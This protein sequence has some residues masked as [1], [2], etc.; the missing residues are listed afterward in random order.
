VD[1]NVKRLDTNEALIQRYHLYDSQNKLTLV[2]DYGSPWLPKNL[3]QRVRFAR[4]DGGFVAALDLSAAMRAKNR[5]RHITY[6]II[7]N[8]AVYAIVNEHRPLPG[9]KDAPPLSHFV[10]EMEG[11][12]WAALPQ[13]P[14]LFV[15]YDASPTSKSPAAQSPAAQ[16]RE[17]IGCI[18]PTSGAYDFTVTL[19]AESLKKAALMA[20]AITFLI[21]RSPLPPS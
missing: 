14:A 5:G 20:L 13:D 16:S 3:R 15:L 10:L 11:M 2:A 1:F 9:N 12:A 6:A 7:I 8:H 17:P 21:D 4:P 18:L 19:P